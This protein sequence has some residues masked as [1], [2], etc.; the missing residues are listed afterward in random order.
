M[1]KLFVSAL[2]LVLFSSVFSQSL[3]KNSVNQLKNL[4]NFKQKTLMV[5]PNH[6]RFLREGDQM[7]LLT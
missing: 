2:C 6:P 7:E 4:S 1:K 5:Q 3:D